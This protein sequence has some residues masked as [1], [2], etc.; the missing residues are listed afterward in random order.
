MLDHLGID[1][2]HVAGYSL[3]AVIAAATAAEAA[4][5]VDSAT[6][7]CGWVVSDARMVFTFD[8]M[9]QADDWLSFFPVG[10]ATTLPRVE[11]VQVM[12]PD[13]RVDLRMFGFKK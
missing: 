10:L 4:G 13:G 5:R 6:L 3:G 11:S 12:R 7:L 8:S 9:S 1:R 2:F